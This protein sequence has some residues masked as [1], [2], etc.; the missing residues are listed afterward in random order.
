MEEREEE[1]GTSSTMK[2]PTETYETLDLERGVSGPNT[3]PVSLTKTPEADRPGEIRRQVG[4][5]P[6]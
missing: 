4:R 1:E 6:R 2:A 3:G 5:G